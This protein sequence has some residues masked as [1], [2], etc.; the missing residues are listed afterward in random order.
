[1]AGRCV[2]L[3][4]GEFKLGA[5]AF[6]MAGWIFPN[7]DDYDVTID[8]GDPAT[9]PGAFVS[10]N[11]PN[12]VALMAAG[13]YELETTEFNAAATYAENEPLYSETDRTINDRGK[14][15]NVASGSAYPSTSVVAVC[16]EARTPTQAA[17]HH[18]T[19]TLKFW[20]VYLPA[21]S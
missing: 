10:V 9:D 3:V 13:S 14:L 2:H 5:E 19:Q 8:G 16:S 12:L 7:S 17:D 21:T 18:F 15:W 20:P 4:A 6:E 1:V 11:T